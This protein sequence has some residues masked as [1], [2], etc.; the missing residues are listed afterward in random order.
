LDNFGILVAKEAFNGSEN[1]ENF[2]EWIKHVINVS[3]VRDPAYNRD[4]RRGNRGERLI[5][6]HN[7]NSSNKNLIT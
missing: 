4:R 5:K 3:S 1:L 7:T 6:L 2:K